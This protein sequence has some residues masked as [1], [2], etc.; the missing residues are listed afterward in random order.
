MRSGARG[1]GTE[2]SAS[3]IGRPTQYPGVVYV[4]RGLVEVL[5]EFARDAEPDE[6]TA[7]LAVTPAGDLVGETGLPPETPVFTDFYLPE[8]GQSVMAVFGMDLSTPARGTQGRFVS[9]PRGELGVSTRDDLHQAV[10]VA[11]PP[12]DRD[13]LGAFDRSGRRQPLEVVDA[14]PPQES[15]A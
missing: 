10:L 4:T 6:F 5:L 11:V 8:A 9:H 14:E 7:G 12:W 3:A 13:S 15:F 1:S 2:A